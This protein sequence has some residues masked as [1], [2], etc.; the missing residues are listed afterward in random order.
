M[1]TADSFD[2]GFGRKD[3]PASLLRPIAE[4]ERLARPMLSWFE[5]QKLPMPII[6]IQSYQANAVGWF[7]W[8]RWE[9]RD[10]AILD[11]INF[12]PE[13]LGRDVFDITETLV[14]ELVHLANYVAGIRDCSSNQYH[15]RHFRDCAL[16]VGLTC[17]RV[18]PYGW[19][20]TELSP[21]LRERIAA[22]KPDSSAFDLFRLP[23]APAPRRTKT[24]ATGIDNGEG[25][26][27][28]QTKRKKLA[29]WR[30]VEGCASLWAAT[31]TDLRAI[32][33]ICESEFSRVE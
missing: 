13:F 18:G 12:V 17:E 4:L 28:V 14:H 2:N 10:G 15:N 6:T 33:L 29:K 24:V 5:P 19:A 11:E 30:C 8:S 9:S 23:P 3:D 27:C 20:K 25:N 16:S 21:K 31:G 1:M 7:A 26:V 22:L 32:C